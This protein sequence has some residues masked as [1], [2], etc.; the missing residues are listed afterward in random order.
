MIVVQLEQSVAWQIF[1]LCLRCI[2]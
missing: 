1:S 2:L